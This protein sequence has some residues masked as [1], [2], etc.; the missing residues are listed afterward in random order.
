[1]R[2]QGVCSV[3]VT[4]CLSLFIKTQM[5]VGSPHCISGSELECASSTSTLKRH[6][7]VYICTYVCVHMLIYCLCEVVH[8]VVILSRSR[9][10]LGQ[11]SS[12]LPPC[13]P[14][15]RVA[16]FGCRNLNSLSLLSLPIC[17]GVVIDR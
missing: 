14:Q 17:P 8:T 4:A 12:L 9:G 10:Q 1:M 13:M 15:R 2:Y 3:Q 7:Y 5:P 11:V 16:R 6:M